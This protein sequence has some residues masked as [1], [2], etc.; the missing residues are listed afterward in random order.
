MIYIGN[1]FFRR[2]NIFFINLQYYNHQ[3]SI[4][5]STSINDIGDVMSSAKL[6]K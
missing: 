5:A 1:V 6:K 2:K 3:K 4:P